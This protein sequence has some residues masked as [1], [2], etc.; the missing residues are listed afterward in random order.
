MNISEILIDPITKQQLA[1]DWQ[2]GVIDNLDQNAFEG[3]IHGKIISILP[4]RADNNST[5]FHE[6][7]GSTFDYVD[8]YK[9]DGDVFDYFKKSDEITENERLRLNQLIINKIE[10]KDRFILDV[11]CGNG[12]VSKALVD[13]NRSVIS[14]DIS[15]TN[16]KRVLK[17]KPHNNHRGVIADVYNLPFRENSFDIIVASEIMEHVH[18]PK[19]FVNCL[20]EVLKPSGKLLITTPYNETI[21][22]SLCVHCNKPTP[23]HAHL[24]SFNEYNA[25]ALVGDNIAQIKIGKSIN[26]HMLKLRVYWLLR[27][28]P[29]KLWQ[30]IDSIVIKLIA[31]PTRLVLE[32]TK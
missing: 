11:G 26:K 10:T 12:W 23:R 7:T 25:K 20:L 22:L 6:S 16:V 9:K 29:F 21:P 32:V 15:D 4:K 30:L 31:K 2:G 24:H 1:V 17:E 13:D 19:L 18:N 14:L 27:F 8:H 28:L 3:N 5:D